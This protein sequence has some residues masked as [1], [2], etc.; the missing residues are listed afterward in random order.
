MNLKKNAK[1]NMSYMLEGIRYV[2]DHFKERGP[3][4]QAERDAQEF[5]KNELGKYSDE[6]IMEDFELHPKAFMGFIPLAAILVILSA[7][8]YWLAPVIGAWVVILGVIFT[9]F[10]VLMFIFEFM[11]Y[12]EFVDF[13]FPKKV[14]RNVYA[15]RKP[16]GEVKRRII[17]GGHA[18]VSPEWT[19]SYLGE[20]KALAPVMAGGILGM[21]VVFFVNLAYLI[22]SLSVGMQTVEIVGVWKILGIVMLVFIPFVFAIIFFINWKVYVDG[23]NDNLSAC[24]IAAAVLKTMADN[25]IRFE[26]TEVGCFISGSEEAGIRGAR[27]FARKHKKELLETESVLIAMDT[28]REIDQ[29]QIY[30]IGC[31]G[32]VHSSKAVGD[33][34]HEAGINCGI[35]MPRA[36][37]YPGAIDSDAWAQ[38][39]LTAA[40]FCGVNHDPKRYYHTRQDTADNIS[41]E[42]IELSLEICLEI[43]ELYDKKGGIKSYEEARKNKK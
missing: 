15:S 17:F 1:D 8:G 26:N 40:G 36:Q 32:T 13:L 37:L 12:G 38:E 23:A 11:F 4:S 43:A 18:D 16:T 41:P 27:A 5:F 21:F 2:C 3:G 39:G 20:I 28:M 9:L 7:A 25:D 35:D 31:T 14:S 19:Y 34:I 22:K 33:L 30:N 29:L 42:C 6:V 24:Y 10:A